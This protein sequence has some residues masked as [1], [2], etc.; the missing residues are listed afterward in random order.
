MILLLGQLHGYKGCVENERKALLELKKYIISI[1]KEEKSGS[2]FPT[3]TDD[4]KSD[5]CLWEG[6]V[7]NQTSRRMT[8]IAFGTLDLK[9]NSLLNLS[10]LHPFEDVRSLNLSGDSFGFSGL[11]DDVEGYKSLKKLRNLEVL[12]LSSN[13]FDNSIL[14]F[15]IAATSLTTLSLRENLMEGSFRAEELKDLTNLELLDMSWN[16]FNGSVQVQE[17]SSLSKLK[18]LDLSNN[19]FSGSLELQ[20]IC[21]LKNIQELDLSHNKLVGQFPLCLTSLSALRVLDLSS[22]RLTGKLPSSLG[23]LA[24]LEYLSLY[25]NDFKSIFSLGSV[26]NL[27]ELRV[28]KLCS[29]SK[30]LQVTTESSLKPRFQLNVIALSSC[31]LEKVPQCLLNQKELRH[32]DLADNNISGKFPSWVLA[33][34]TQLKVLLVQNNLFTSFQL[35]KSPH[36]LLLMDVSANKFSH[37]VPGNIGWILPELRGM[38]ISK[39]AFHGK[40]PSSLGNMK[41]IEFMDVSHNSFQGR[42]PRSLLKGCYSLKILKLSNNKLSGEVFQEPTTNITEVIALSMNNNMFTG[43]IGQGLRSLRVLSMLDI[44]NNNLTGD[45]PEWVGELPSLR[46]LLISNNSLEGEIPISLFNS[47]TL[48]LLDL[49]ANILSG[50]IPPQVSSVSS[51]VI[52]LLQD[53]NL[54]GAIPDT[55]LRNVEI[56]D[57]RNNKLF[58]NIPEFINTQN[59]SVLLLRGNSLT[60]CIPRQLCDLSD[61]HLLDLSKNRLNGPIPSCF[62]NTSFGLE[63]GDDSLHHFYDYSF[64]YYPKD[65]Q[66]SSDLELRRYFKTMLMLD[67]FSI[68]GCRSG[69]QT[70]IEFAT[71]HRYDSYMGENL[72][73]MI[74]MDLSENELSGEI[75]FELGD[76]HKLHALNLSHNQL[77]GEIPRSF[78]GLKNVESLDL[79]FNGLQGEIPSQLAELSNLAVFNV[80]FNNL[81]GVIPQGKQFNTFDTQS[82]LGNPSLCGKQTNTSCDGGNSIHT[83]ADN[84]V[85]DEESKI[86]MESFYLSSAAAFVK[87][88]LGVFA[89]LSF[90][91]PWSRFWFYMV[92]AFIHKVTELFR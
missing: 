36:N 65:S 23:S 84:V 57:L 92:D 5:C 1:T 74:G 47:A 9:E 88:L 26:T 37:L 19:D 48:G 56:L 28:L 67:Q 59:T 43:K 45:I 31:N 77:S 40:L 11:F 80:S 49:S 20:G 62:R 85:K 73:L 60:G 75:P 68:T 64:T 81:S 14:P 58:G 32:V 7:C 61:T 18:A 34:N 35:P 53:N 55:L 2:V 17:L 79:S 76:L 6:V 86:D 91:S 54:S 51:N 12:D 10:L 44:S 4:T 89:S 30:S 3:W 52:L 39:N 27:S 63:K 71:K 72:G 41:K 66:V 46:A 38:N 87:T 83:P 15:L 90:D 8:T 13:I 25:D 42:L 24:Y 33:N 78:S 69:A 16:G 29:K 21:E 82:F 50:P 70:K 22:N